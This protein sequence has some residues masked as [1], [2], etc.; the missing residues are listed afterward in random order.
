MLRCL[1]QCLCRK[2]EKNKRN[3]KEYKKSLREKVCQICYQNKP[4]YYHIHSNEA[5]HC[6]LCKEE[7]MKI[8]FE[9]NKMKR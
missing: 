9:K 3:I 2:D 1:S 7:G 6:R 8:F 4:L 5:T